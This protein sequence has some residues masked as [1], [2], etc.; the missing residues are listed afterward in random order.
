MS[1]A[2]VIRNNSHECSLN[3]YDDESSI[4]VYSAKLLNP[5]SDAQRL[6]SNYILLLVTFVLF[7][8]NNHR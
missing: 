1:D 8:N 3:H 6:L 4:S 2:I 7:V 5:C